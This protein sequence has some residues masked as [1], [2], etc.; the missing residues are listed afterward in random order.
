MKDRGSQHSASSKNSSVL[1]QGYS[2]IAWLPEGEKSWTLPLR[3][4][5]ITSFETP[6]SK[7]RWQLKQVCKEIKEQKIL[8][9]KEL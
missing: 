3:H 4:E 7:A 2:T 1:G 6:I 8:V 9:V 5:R